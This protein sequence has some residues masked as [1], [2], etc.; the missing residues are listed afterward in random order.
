MDTKT[1]NVEI[2][3]DADQTKVWF[4]T[5]FDAEGNTIGESADYFHKAGAVAYARRTFRG[6][7]V[8]VRGMNGQDLYSFDILRE[9]DRVGT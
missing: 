2:W 6:V 9:G 5:A 3:Y 7:T 4:V 1:H 8:N